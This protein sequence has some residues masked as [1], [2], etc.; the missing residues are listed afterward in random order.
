MYTS[1]NSETLNSVLKRACE[2][3]E[4]PVDIVVIGFHLLQNCDYY[5]ILRGISGT[6]DFHLKPEYRRAYV[7][8]DEIIIPQK[9]VCPDNVIDYIKNIKVNSPVES[10]NKPRNKVTE[11]LNFD[12]TETDE[13]PQNNEGNIEEV[14]NENIDFDQFVAINTEEISVLDKNCSQQA[15]ARYIV[16]NNFI[17][18][19]P[20]QGVF[21]VHGRSNEYCVT[22]F[23]K[24]T[25]QCPSTTT[26][27]YILAVKISIGL[28]P[29]EKKRVVNLRVLSTKSKKN[30][31]KKSGRK[32]PR[33]ND[34]ETE[35]EPAPNSIFV[36]KTPKNVN[37][38][39]P[40]P[41]SKTKT[42]FKTPSKS[43]FVTPK[44]KKKNCRLLL[45]EI[46][47]TFVHP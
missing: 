12:Q 29:I 35:I 36:N 40:P 31:H 5:E 42:P 18:L 6:G 34:I 8:P 7:A 10:T 21:V 14:E 9:I 20:S 15:S 33:P 28:Q 17:L 38:K 19:V 47:L 30:I 4:L 3:T 11:I 13:N 26:C 32:Q 46:P 16:E 1:N 39:P 45:Q 43:S 2:W 37:S 24:E 22:V 44:S 25:C 27:H 41:S 23:L